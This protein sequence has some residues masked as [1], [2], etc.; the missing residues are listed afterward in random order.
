MAAFRKNQMGKL[1]QFALGTLCGAAGVLGGKSYRLYRR[2]LTAAEQ[3]IQ[4]QAQTIE[5]NAGRVVYNISGEG[6]PVL[7]I[8]GAGGGFDQALHVAKN[9]GSIFQ[10]IA[11]CRF[12]YL[13]SD[14]PDDAS[15]KAQ[16]DA[17]AALLDALDIRCV[18]I[19]GM[20]A[21]GPSA[22]QFA[23]RHPERCSGLLLIAAVSKAMLAVAANPETMEKIFDWS[24]SSDWAI[25]LGLQLAIHKFRPP[26]GVSAKVIQQINAVDEAWLRTLLTYELPIQPR[27]SGLLND[28]RSILRLDVLPM[29]QI[30][31]PALV[32]HARDDSLVPIKHGRSSTRHIP[33]ARLVELPS[34]GHLL[35][36]QRE[37]VK[38]E[39]EPFLK[40]VIRCQ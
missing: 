3:R 6:Q 18:P 28:F 20:S 37:R 39:V 22:I 17:Y 13:G 26:L 1:K 24:L 32:I 19:I 5:T 30:Q 35:L 7:V 14:L 23:L 29:E 15:P 25:W 27:R 9:F 4:S 8:H 21:G 38:S 11:P 36:G 33:N 34:G 12:G 10:W 31:T 40:S 2:D 16:A